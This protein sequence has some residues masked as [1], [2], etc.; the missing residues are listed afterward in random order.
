MLESSIF[1]GWWKMIL[2]G[3]HKG[4]LPPDETDLNNIITKE[5]FDQT[6][7]V[8]GNDGIRDTL[9]KMEGIIS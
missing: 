8:S 3:K 6:Y 9:R 2:N 4:F 1:D 5:E 7:N